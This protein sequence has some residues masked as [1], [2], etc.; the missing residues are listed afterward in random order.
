MAS[1]VS[2]CMAYHNSGL[3]HPGQLTQK[4][5]NAD[6]EKVALTKGKNADL[7]DPGGLIG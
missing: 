1:L 2:A 3:Y 4:K 6:K 5:L 7:G